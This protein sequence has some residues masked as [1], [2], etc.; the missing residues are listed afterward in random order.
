MKNLIIFLLTTTFVFAQQNGMV[1]DQN[2]EPLP[3]ASVVIK[4][5]TTGTTTDFNGKFSLQALRFE[6]LLQ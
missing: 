3:G 4:G 6:N 2:N 1:V 5:T